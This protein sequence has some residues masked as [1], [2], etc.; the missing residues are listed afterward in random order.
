MAGYDGSQ[1]LLDPMC[2]SGHPCCEPPTSRSNAHRAA[3]AASA[4]SA[5]ANLTPCPGKRC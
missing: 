3:N 5:C 2:G 1:P 4:S